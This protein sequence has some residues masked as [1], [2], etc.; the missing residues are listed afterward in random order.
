MHHRRLPAFTPSSHNWLE[1]YS[2]LPLCTPLPK[3]HATSTAVYLFIV[4]NRASDSHYWSSH[5]AC[6][7]QPLL[8]WYLLSAIIQMSLASITVTCSTSNELYCDRST[9]HHRYCLPAGEFCVVMT[10]VPREWIYTLATSG[11]AAALPGSAPGGGPAPA[12]KGP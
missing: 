8:T 2:F 3:P 5:T 11:R 10:G 1:G 6:T 7:L 4:D 9:S 12:P